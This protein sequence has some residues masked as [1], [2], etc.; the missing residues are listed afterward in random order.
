MSANNQPNSA[1]ATVLTI[2]LSADDLDALVDLAA[3]VSANMDDPDRIAAIRMDEANCTLQ[4]DIAAR[5][6]DPRRL[7]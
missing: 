3:T 4:M 5:P 7:H 1:P 6:V 2:T